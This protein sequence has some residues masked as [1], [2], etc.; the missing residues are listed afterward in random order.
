MDDLRNSI[1]FRPLLTPI[2]WGRAARDRQGWGGTPGS[3]P[4]CLPVTTRRASNNPSRRNCCGGR[5]Q[6]TRQQSFDGNFLGRMDAAD[7]VRFSGGTAPTRSF[8]RWIEWVTARWRMPPCKPMTTHVVERFFRR[9]VANDA[10]KVSPTRGAQYSKAAT[11]HSKNSRRIPFST[12]TTNEWLV[13]LT[14]AFSPALCIFQCL[15][16]IV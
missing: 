10:W 15:A 5:R 14:V 1:L 9:N 3:V 11:N 4:Q 16:C 13:W 2:S 8:R 6:N 7:R 12:P